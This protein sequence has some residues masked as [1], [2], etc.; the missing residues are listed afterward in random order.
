M[1]QKVSE[2]LLICLVMKILPVFCC[3]FSCLKFNFYIFTTV[4]LSKTCSVD[5]NGVASEENKKNSLIHVTAYVK[6]FL[7]YVRKRLMKLFVFLFKI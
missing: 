5:K 1:P 7:L 6:M 2:N 4:N 3:I